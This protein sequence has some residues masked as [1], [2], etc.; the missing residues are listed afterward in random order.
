MTRTV[1]AERI[2]R[3]AP[4]QAY[5]AYWDLDHWPRALD[6]IVS[7]ETQYDDGIHQYFSMTVDKSGALETVRGV[8]IGTPFEAIE[9]CQL[10]PPPGFSI[11]RGS[12]KFR[13]VD[14]TEAVA[15]R[16]VVERTFER[17]DASGDDRAAA[18]LES[19]LAKNLAAFDAYLARGAA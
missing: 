9:L 7:V 4:E 2:F 5:L 19:L 10:Q 1:S 18:L 11:M 13:A 12:W 15:T 8:R 17:I 6:D 3:T 16:V 14:G